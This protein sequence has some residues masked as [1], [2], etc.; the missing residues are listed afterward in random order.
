MKKLIYAIHAIN[1]FLI[2]K[3]HVKQSSKKMSLDPIPDEL[4]DFKKSEKTLTS[5]KITLNKYQ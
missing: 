3:Y 1:T 5:K 2:M 4:R